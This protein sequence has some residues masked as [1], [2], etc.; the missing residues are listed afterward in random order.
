MILAEAGFRSQGFDTGL[1]YL[2]AFRAYMAAG[3]YLTNADP[4]QVKYDAYDAADF[5]NG[6]MENMDGLSADDALLREILEERYVTFFGQ[7]EGFND[8]RRTENETT[9]RVPIQPNVGTQLPQR[10]L[11]P[12]TEIDR[13]SNTPSPIPGFFE[14]TDVNN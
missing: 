2:N 3:G 12:Q 1:N 10:F 11:Y 14:P 9:V 7:T 13:N 6:G 5:N 4:A 8:T